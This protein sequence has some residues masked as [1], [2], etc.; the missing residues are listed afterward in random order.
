MRK[1]CAAIL[2]ASIC[3]FAN[4]FDEESTLQSPDE[5]AK[6]VKYE[7]DKFERESKYT[8][9]IYTDGKYGNAFYHDIHLRAFSSGKR[10]VSYQIYVTTYYTDSR[11]MHYRNAF[12]DHGTRLSLTPIGYD[13]DTSEAYNRV[14]KVEDFAI[15]V[16]KEYLERLAKRP[17]VEFKITGPG[18]SMRFELPPSHIEGFLRGMTEAKGKSQ[19]R[20]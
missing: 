7:F 1:I 2:M 10:P 3:N 17:D 12:D 15:N 8:G 18:G 11:W 13:V 5:V 14:Y 16:S 19:V 9:P 20:P 6:E 4:A